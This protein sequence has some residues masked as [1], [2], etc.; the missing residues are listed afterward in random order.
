[1]MRDL[2][3]VPITFRPV[4]YNPARRELRVATRVEIE[5]AFAGTD[6]R[7]AKTGRRVP[8]TPDFERLYDSMVVNH[9]RDAERLV[10]QTQPTLG[11]LGAHH[12]Q[13]QRRSARGCSRSS[14]G[15]SAW[16]STYA[17]PRPPRR[18]PRRTTCATGSS[19]PTRP[20]PTRPSTS[21]SPAT[22]PATY[23]I[24]TF[25]ENVSGYGGEGDH[26]YSL[27][28]GTDDVP[29]AFVGRLSFETLDAARDDRGEDP[30]LR[31]DALPDRRRAG[32]R[33]PAS[34]ATSPPATPASRSSSG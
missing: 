30:R 3:V 17:S 23:S 7:N 32:S 8:S 29:E 28:E 25:H 27:L 26:P 6:P 16:A 13:Q 9:A 19:T 1:M 15:A 12:A 4:R 18:A 14:T 20:G 21:C 22:P 34:W 5:I 24:P 11:A 2:R 31:E 33:R 10:S